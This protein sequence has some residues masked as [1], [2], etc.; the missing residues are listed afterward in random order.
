VNEGKDHA[1]AK[2]HVEDR[3][4]QSLGRI[5][6][7]LGLCSRWGNPGDHRPERREQLLQLG[8]DQRFVFSLL[9]GGGLYDRLGSYTKP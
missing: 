4:I 9:G 2:P 8:S 7:G 3:G 5:C 6:Q 1:V